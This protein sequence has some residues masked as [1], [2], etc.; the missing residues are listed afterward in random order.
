MRFITPGFYLNHRSEPAQVGH[1]FSEALAK[2][3][4]TTLTAN[5][6]LCRGLEVFR[7]KLIAS[8]RSG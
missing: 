2:L 7:I 3:G 1:E 4:G 8:D 6:E 5:T